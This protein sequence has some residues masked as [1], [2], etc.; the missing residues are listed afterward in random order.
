[1][2]VGQLIFS[3]AMTTYIFIGI[4]LEERDLLKKIGEAYEEY[5]RQGSMIIPLPRKK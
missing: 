3:L 5:R 2:S 1:M 4:A